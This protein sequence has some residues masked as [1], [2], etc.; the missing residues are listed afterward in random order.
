MNSCHCT[1]TI[2]LDEC[3]FIRFVTTTEWNI[4]NF[5]NAWMSKQ[6]RSRYRYLYLKQIMYNI[7]NSL[8]LRGCENIFYYLIH[9]HILLCFLNPRVGVF[10]WRVKGRGRGDFFA[11]FFSRSLRNFWPMKMRHVTNPLFSRFM[12]KIE[13]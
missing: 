10:R 8:R 13:K 1:K 5:W 6:K 4:T 7:H 12:K 3:K 9:R 11:E 2:S